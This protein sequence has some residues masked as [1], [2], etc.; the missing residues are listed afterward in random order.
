MGKLSSPIDLFDG[1][2]LYAYLHHHPSYA[3]DLY[4]LEEEPYYP[5]REVEHHDRP[6]TQNATQDS[7]KQNEAP[8][9]LLEKLKRDKKDRFFFCGFSQIRE[10][11]IGFINGVMNTLRDAHAS[12]KALSE[13]AGGHFVSFVYNRSCG[14]LLMDLARSFCEIYFYAKTGAVK[15]LMVNIKT[16]LDNAGPNAYYYLECHSEGAAVARNALKYLSDKYRKKVIL[17]AIAPAAYTPEKYA[18]QVTHVVSTRD[19]VPLFDFVGAYR[20][21]NTTVRLSPHPDAPLFDHPVDS[22]TYRDTRQ[23]N[24]DL[25]INTYGGVP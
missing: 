18:F 12:A 3:F 9:G 5:L 2:N 6:N 14:N 13:M 25:Y 24:L 17:L 15:N 21:R 22:P 16:Y 10:L 11:G 4:G 20:C 8:I 7:D 23:G 1:P 19:I